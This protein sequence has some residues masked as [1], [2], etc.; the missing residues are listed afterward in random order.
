MYTSFYQCDGCNERHP[1]THDHRP[2]RDARCPSCGDA[3][4]KTT[5]TVCP[6]C[7]DHRDVHAS[8]YLVPAEVERWTCA[9]GHLNLNR[10]L[11]LRRAS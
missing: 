11:P 9:N 2:E 8:V 10:G 5:L 1:L 3:V 4:R 7:R 6:A